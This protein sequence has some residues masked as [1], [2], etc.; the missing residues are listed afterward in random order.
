[1]AGG[2]LRSLYGPTKTQLEAY[3]I[4]K[5]QYA[6]LKRG[7]GLLVE[8]GLPDLERKLDDAG[9]PWTPGRGVPGY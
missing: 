7:L 5:R 1:M 6:E 3:S 2:G 4:A 9:L 8:K